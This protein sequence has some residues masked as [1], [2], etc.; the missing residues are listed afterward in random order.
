[1]LYVSRMQNARKYE[2]HISALN[3]GNPSFHMGNYL[4]ACPVSESALNF[5]IPGLT[6]IHLQTQRL[7]IFFKNDDK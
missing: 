5:R 4:H 2:D 6:D 3:R 7:S 1:M